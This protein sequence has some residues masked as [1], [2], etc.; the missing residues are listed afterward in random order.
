L[1]KEGKPKEKKK[2]HPFPPRQQEGGREKKGEG[3]GNRFPFAQKGRK[4]P[5]SGKRGEKDAFVQYNVP[6]G[7]GGGGLSCLR[8]IEGKQETH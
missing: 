8:V 3:R 4:E 2:R 6:G 1:D 5:G 7:E